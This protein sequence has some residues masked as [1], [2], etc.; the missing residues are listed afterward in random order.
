MRLTGRRGAARL[1]RGLAATGVWLAAVLTVSVWTFTLTAQVPAHAA[2][3]R[4]GTQLAALDARLGEAQRALAPLDPL[5]RPE[6]FRTVRA[7][8]VLAQT[9]RETPLLE[10]VFG[11]QTLAD[12][13]SLTADWERA[14]AARPP[15][16]ALTEARAEVAGWLA[17]VGA[18][19]HRLTLTVWG[20]NAVTLILGVWFAAG[21]VA[22]Y[23]AADR[24]L[25]G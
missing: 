10:Q 21:Q 9:A 3:D 4:A 25:R 6:T 24:Q 20:V 12:A 15:V 1:A 22:L 14:L 18:A 8:N 23:R 2:L 7:L 13:A 11:T 17:R 19:R 16:P 5:T